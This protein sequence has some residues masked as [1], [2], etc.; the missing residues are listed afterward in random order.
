MSFPPRPELHCL[1]VAKLEF[2]S[3]PFSLT[4]CSVAGMMTWIALEPWSI[5]FD[6]GLVTPQLVKCGTLIITHGHMDHAG[7]L[8]TWLAMRRLNGLGPSRVFAP[9]EICEVLERIVEQWERMHRNPFD[10]TLTPMQPGDR[11]ELSPKLVVEALPSDHVVPTRAWAIYQ[12]H[13]KL[14]PA[15]R[16]LDGPAINAIKRKGEAVNEVTWKPMFAITGDS[17]ATTIEREPV[18][19]QAAVACVECTFLDEKCPVDRARKGGHTHLD[20]LIDIPWKNRFVVPYHISQRYNL[21]QAKALFQQK[22]APHLPPGVQLVP[23]LPA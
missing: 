13:S 12:Q 14:K 23:M 2:D 16:G 8:G 19:T 6:C 20:E 9:A 4:G 7:G 17:R 15:L 5:G 18:F 3:L 11:V 1:G 10:W 22:W 21:S